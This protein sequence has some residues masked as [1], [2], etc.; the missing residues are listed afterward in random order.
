[1]RERDFAVFDL[2]HPAFAP[3]LAHR[4]NQEEDSRIVTTAG[5]ERGDSCVLLA[6]QEQGVAE[7]AA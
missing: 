7:I 1:M 6:Q 4:F 3:D 2:P 5:I